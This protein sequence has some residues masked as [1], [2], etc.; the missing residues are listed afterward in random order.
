MEGQLVRCTYQNINQ[1]CF[2]G[3]G[4]ACVGCEC[5]WRTEWR[6]ERLSAHVRNGERW[7]YASTPPTASPAVLFK[8]MRHTSCQL[9]AK[10]LLFCHRR[11]SRSSIQFR[12]VPFRSFTDSMSDS[13]KKKKRALSNW[14]CWLLLELMEMCFS[15]LGGFSM[16]QIYCH[17]CV[18]WNLKWKMIIAACPRNKCS[19]SLY[20]FFYYKSIPNHTSFPNH[21]QLGSSQTWTRASTASFQT[22]KEKHLLP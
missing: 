3:R 12:A 10:W 1:W 8:P 22:R 7:G 11:L 16:S 18:Y 13:L 2:E 6:Y 14:A 15:M 9:L 4:I 17:G 19:I 20:I 5:V 21:N